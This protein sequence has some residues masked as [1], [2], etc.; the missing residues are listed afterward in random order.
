MKLKN[1][2]E[3]LFLLALSRLKLISFN[4]EREHTVIKLDAI[5]DFYVWLPFAKALFLK[6]NEEKRK[7]TLV[8]NSS[9]KELVNLELP[10]V[11]VISVDKTRLNDFSYKF[12]LI[13]EIADT[14]TLESPTYS[15][16]LDSGFLSILPRCEKRV[17]MKGDTTNVKEAF[18]RFFNLFFDDLIG[19]GETYN[20]ESTKFQK[21]YKFKPIF[22]EE[23]L[24]ENNILVHI[25]ASWS[26]RRWPSEKINCLIEK[27]LELTDEKIILLG[28]PGDLNFKEQ[29][30]SHPRVE[31]RIGETSLSELR[32][33]IRRSKLLISNETS[34][35][36]MAYVFNKKAIVL[37]GGG[38]FGR[39]LPYP[40]NKKRNVR[41][42]FEKME[43]FLCNWNC[44]FDL[45]ERKAVPCIEAIEVERVISEVKECLYLS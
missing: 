4:N 41:C 37:L 16:D 23:S 11:E 34:V 29:M 24:E 25:G 13:K 27:L 26:Y 17:G 9:Y 38:H 42:V 39:F 7:L 14:K 18:R 21:F 20:H 43:C 3:W 15:L 40:S 22:R 36:H 44:I 12:S 30:V 45:N 31:S 35:S 8:I 1:L 33:L 10:D 6:S 28:G 2:I 32:E 5:G 19:V